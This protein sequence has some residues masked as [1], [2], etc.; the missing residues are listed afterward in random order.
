M[1]PPLCFVHTFSHSLIHPSQLSH[2]NA[3]TPQAYLVDRLDSC[4]GRCPR[5]AVQIRRNHV[6]LQSGIRAQ[7][8]VARGGKQVGARGDHIL[9]FYRLFTFADM[10]MMA[11][12]AVANSAALPLQHTTSCAVSLW[13]RSSLSTSLSRVPS[14][15]I[16]L[17]KHYKNSYITLNILLYYLNLKNYKIFSIDRSTYKLS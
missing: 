15:Q 5:F 14:S 2:D 8:A 7:C 9:L 13:S 16:R 6:G 12:G 1:S 11:L 10:T 4:V 3:C 17:P